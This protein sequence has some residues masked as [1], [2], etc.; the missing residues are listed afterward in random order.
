LEEGEAYVFLFTYIYRYVGFGIIG[1]LRDDQYSAG[2]PY[3]ACPWVWHT[4]QRANFKKGDQVGLVGCVKDG[5]YLCNFFINDQ[6]IPWYNY[7]SPY[8]SSEKEIFLHFGVVTG[9][10]FTLT[11]PR[12][13]N[14]YYYN[15]FKNSPAYEKGIFYRGGL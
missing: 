15:K 7:N 8:L 11:R 12:L 1:Q 2:S 6:F 13:G 9:E 3:F 14:Y 4:L 5:Y 10:K